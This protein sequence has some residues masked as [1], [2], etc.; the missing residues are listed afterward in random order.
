MADGAANPDPSAAVDGF[1]RFLETSSDPALPAEVI[2]PDD[3]TGLEQARDTA[4]VV[5]TEA[6]IRDALVAAQRRV[7]D[8]TM[9]QYRRQ[10]F[11]AAYL[12]SWLD[13]PEQRID[14]VTI[15]V[16]AATAYA[17]AGLLDDDTASTL[18]ARYEDYHEGLGNA[19]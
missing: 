2:P 6:G 7:A 16:D 1:I 11:R 17:L 14:V 9:E 4:R 13:E 8:W 10:G 12:S 18:T 5:A 15:L 19:P 3:V